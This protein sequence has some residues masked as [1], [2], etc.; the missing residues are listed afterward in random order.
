MISA[1]DGCGGN[2][3]PFA[4]RRSGLDRISARILRS[5]EI[6]KAVGSSSV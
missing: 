6:I 3:W 4:P 1:G 2:A 5:A